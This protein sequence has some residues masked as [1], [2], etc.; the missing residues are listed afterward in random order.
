MYFFKYFYSRSDLL[1]LTRVLCN[2]IVG[3]QQISIRKHS[4]GQLAKLCSKIRKAS[5]EIS[6]HPAE[7]K[8]QDEQWQEK[9]KSVQ[10]IVK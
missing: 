8:D 9:Y 5:H 10:K 3:G 4:G 2:G 1:A 7:E 6:L